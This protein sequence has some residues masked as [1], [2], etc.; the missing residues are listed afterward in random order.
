[1]NDDISADQTDDERRA[2]GLSPEPRP[3][4]E[5]A[6]KFDAPKPVNVSFWLWVAGSVLQILGQIYY[7]VGKEQVIDIYAK[8]YPSIPRDR[9]AAS[10]PGTLWLVLIAAIVLSGLIL[11]FAYKA[12]EGTRSARTVLTFLAVLTALFYAV[13]FVSESAVVAV[14]LYVIALL[15]MYIPSAQRYFPKVG[16]K[17]P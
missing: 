12:R 8:R 17:L 13:I 15:L 4:G 2:A 11:L 10:L 14:L 1:V 9:W 16:R 6:P 3:A 7:L 5:P